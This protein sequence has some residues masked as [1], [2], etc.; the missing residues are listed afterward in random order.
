MSW[1]DIRILKEDYA[2]KLARQERYLDEKRAILSLV[3]RQ[4]SWHKALDGGL[5]MEVRFPFLP[6]AALSC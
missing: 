4:A 6:A 1:Q 3:L 5:A 2:R